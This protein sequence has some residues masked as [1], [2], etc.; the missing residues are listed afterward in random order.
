MSSFSRRKLVANSS[1]K[2]RTR[3]AGPQRALTPRAQLCRAAS[4]TI[5]CHARLPQKLE[6]AMALRNEERACV[7]GAGPAGLATARAFK[8]YGIPF[9]VYERHRAIGGIWDQSNP[10]SPVYDSTH[11][12][13]SKTQ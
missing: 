8:S 9:D 5:G 13:S 11:F 3:A 12:I 4:G 1:E 10:G 2:A 6:L 7:I